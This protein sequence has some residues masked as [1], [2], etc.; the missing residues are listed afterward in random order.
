MS[1]MPTKDDEL[2]AARR[3]VEHCES[4]IEGLLKLSTYHSLF[5]TLA[6]QV[7][8]YLQLIDAPSTSAEQLTEMQ[9]KFRNTIKKI[10]EE[11]EKATQEINLK[12]VE[13]QEKQNAAKV[14]GQIDE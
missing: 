1:L 3:Q 14:K 9:E 13:I 10:N 4:L 6:S 7:Q 12:F 2:K 8:N 11:R 5:E